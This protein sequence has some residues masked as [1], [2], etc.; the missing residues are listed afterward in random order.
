MGEWISFFYCCMQNDLSVTKRSTLTEQLLGFPPLFL[1]IF[2]SHILICQSLKKITR[3]PKSNES[4]PT[5]FSLLSHLP[6]VPPTLFSFIT[7]AACNPNVKLVHENASTLEL[8]WRNTWRQKFVVSCKMDVRFPLFSAGR[9]KGDLQGWS[10]AD[11][12]SGGSS[13]WDLN[14]QRYTF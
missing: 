14:M 10:C 7:S 12:E 4:F 11:E 2:L 3:D 8:W 1:Y 6:T 5:F 9:A 13:E